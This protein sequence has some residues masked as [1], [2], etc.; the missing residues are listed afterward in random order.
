M[1]S[2]APRRRVTVDV[3]GPAAIGATPSGSPHSVSGEPATPLH[4]RA[5][6][7]A[8]QPDASPTV[9]VH[10]FV[11]PIHLIEGDDDAPSTE[12]SS[13][14]E[15]MKRSPSPLLTAR[16]AP[17]SKLALLLPL[18]F[19][20]LSVALWLWY[21]VAYLDEL[22][23]WDNASCDSTSGGSTALLA[24]GDNSTSVDSGILF[25]SSTGVAEASA[26]STR[27]EIAKM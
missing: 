18:F 23:G 20:A 10:T 7:A 15:P 5:A 22:S 9:V 2:A 8:E 25:P 13:F 14:I 17:L 27:G 26:A 1:A 4:N 16:S 19:A 11:E 21:L 3:N 12:A 24:P 6:E